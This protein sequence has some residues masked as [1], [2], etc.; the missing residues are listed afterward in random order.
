MGEPGGPPVATL[1]SSG[2]DVTVAGIVIQDG[3]AAWDNGLLTGKS[4]AE[5]GIAFGPEALRAVGG[6]RTVG[7]WCP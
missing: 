1:R 4:K 7:V 2:R 5:Q 6:K 3:K